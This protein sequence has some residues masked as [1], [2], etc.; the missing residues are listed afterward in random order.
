MGNRNK[1]RY[2]ES[3]HLFRQI[4]VLVIRSVGKK[5]KSLVQRFLGGAT[6]NGNA[7]VISKTPST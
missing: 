2:R 7:P 4:A 5:G 3:F 6:V 1:R